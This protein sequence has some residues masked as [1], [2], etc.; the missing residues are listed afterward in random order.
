MQIVALNEYDYVC[1]YDFRRTNEPSL[2]VTKPWAYG[3]KLTSVNPRIFEGVRVRLLEAWF[4]LTLVKKYQN[5][6]V[7]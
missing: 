1:V 5:L 3:Q 2:V 6:Y 7:S 4:A